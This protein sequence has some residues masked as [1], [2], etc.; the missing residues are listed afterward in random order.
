MA[1]SVSVS[2]PV[3]LVLAGPSTITTGNTGKC[4]QHANTGMFMFTSLQRTL[5]RK[6][7]VSN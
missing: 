1:V 4:G 2:A 7:L 6:V 5:K 3:P